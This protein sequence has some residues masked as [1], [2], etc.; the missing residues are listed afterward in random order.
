MARLPPKR[1]R[2]P[3]SPPLIADVDPNLHT[4]HGTANA[5]R[6]IL[7]S[8][9]DADGPSP[10]PPASVFRVLSATGAR[11]FCVA[12]TDGRLHRL[13]HRRRR[14]A[15]HTPRV[16]AVPPLAMSTSPPAAGASD[17][18]PA[19]RNAT[20]SSLGEW[21]GRCGARS[22]PTPAH[23]AEHTAGRPSKFPLS[24]KMCFGGNRTRDLHDPHPHSNPDADTPE[25]RPHSRCPSLY[26]QCLRRADSARRLRPRGS[27]RGHPP[28]LRLFNPQNAFVR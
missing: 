14:R 11:L 13:C 27:S 7:P 20:S 10:M 6:R 4:K 23:T 5:L 1:R 18:P 2:R 24:P 17:V 21:L 26:C 22:R 9:A 28:W 3:P 8:H 25:A 15:S 19:A 16:T 12:A